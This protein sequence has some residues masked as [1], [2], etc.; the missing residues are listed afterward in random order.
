ML[1]SQCCGGLGG[2]IDGGGCGGIGHSVAVVV[3][4][5][6]MAVVAVALVTVDVTAMSLRWSSRW[7][8]GGVV[9][10]SRCYRERE[11]VAYE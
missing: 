6:S 11:K 3:V 5:M 1:N 9:V 2:D 4:E 8:H 7:H 10:A